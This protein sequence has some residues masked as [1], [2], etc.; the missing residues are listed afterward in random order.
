MGIKTDT[1]LIGQPGYYKALDGLLKNQPIM[2]WKDKAAFG[3]LDGA[4]TSL[5]KSFVKAH[6]D[7][8][9][10]VLNGQKVQ[11]E[12]WKTMVDKVDGS[13]GELLGQ[14]YVE[15]YFPSDAKKRM[16][17]LVDKQQ[18]EKHKQKQKQEKKSAETK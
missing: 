5:S 3:A 8:Y 18:N 11:K 16:L 13:L 15:K 7:F 9:G 17:D 6:F 14:L 2:E 1:V 12:R 10:K 4:A